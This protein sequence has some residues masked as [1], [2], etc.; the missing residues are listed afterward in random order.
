MN[1]AYFLSITKR[2][3]GL[4]GEVCDVV[5]AQAPQVE[6]RAEAKRLLSGFAAFVRFSPKKA[7]DWIE[8]IGAAL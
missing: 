1:H 5:Q 4:V 8:S 6:A 2:A 3:V 7:A